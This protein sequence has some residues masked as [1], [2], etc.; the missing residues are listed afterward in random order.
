MVVSSF[1]VTITSLSRSALFFIA[2]FRAHPCQSSQK[3]SFLSTY[4]GGP[5]PLEL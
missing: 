5:Q 2:E 4:S 3:V 1:E